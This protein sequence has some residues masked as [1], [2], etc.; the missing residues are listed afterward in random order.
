M[1]NIKYIP[2]IVG[3]TFLLATVLIVHLLFSFTIVAM[4]VLC[5]KSFAKFIDDCDK[6]LA[7]LYKQVIEIVD[8]IVMGDL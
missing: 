3:A 2:L 1:K 4:E 6:E 5:F 7:N 8:R